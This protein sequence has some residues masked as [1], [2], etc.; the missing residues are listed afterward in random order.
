MSSLEERSL[1]SLADMILNIRWQDLLEI[2]SVIRKKMDSE[3]PAA[4][5]TAFENAKGR[6]LEG[7]LKDH[8]EVRWGMSFCPHCNDENIDKNGIAYPDPSG[9]GVEFNQCLNCRI[10]ILYNLVVA[11]ATMEKYVIGLGD[12]DQFNGMS[13]FWDVIVPT[14]MSKFQPMYEIISKGQWSGTVS[15]DENKIPRFLPFEN[16]KDYASR[17]SEEGWTSD[18]PPDIKSAIDAFISTASEQIDVALAMK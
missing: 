14:D 12:P 4:V 1:D 18:I 13:F 6:I 5:K 8:T 7:A 3:G 16:M 15:F 17:G 10:G 11:N 9:D 2:F